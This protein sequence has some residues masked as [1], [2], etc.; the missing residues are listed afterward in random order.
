MLLQTSVPMA[1]RAAMRGIVGSLNRAPS[2][3]ALA[4]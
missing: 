4:F 1:M 3:R 2:S